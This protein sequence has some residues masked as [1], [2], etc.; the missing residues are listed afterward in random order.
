[1]LFIAVGMPRAGS[2]WHYN[3][4]HDLVV[5][6]GGTD[7]RTIRK[8]FL[9]APIL[10]E[11]NCNIGAMNPH[12][13]LP[14]MVPAVFGSRFVIKA[15]SRPTDIVR[16]FIEGGTIRAT[17][18]YRDPRAALLSAYDYGKHGLENGIP[19]AFSNL[20]TI[21]K[22]V[23][24]I[25]KYVYQREDWIRIP[26][27]LHTRY[28]DFLSDYD[29]EVARILELL[30]IKSETS[31]VLAAVA[32]YRPGQ[33]AEGQHLGLHYYKGQP[34]RFRTALTPEQLAYCNEVLGPSIE[35]MGYTL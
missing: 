5:A 8:R 10:T 30:E 9:L 34:E 11:V 4:I 35:K 17:Y 12:R 23:E 16:R 3:L 21:E 22:A 27:V 31:A 13:L 20:D 1:M 7:A 32:K 2:G 29:A 18:I 15:H 33:Q 26:E 19:N 24:F 6:S 14:V 28:E 25:K